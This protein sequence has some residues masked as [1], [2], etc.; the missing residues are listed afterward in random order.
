[1]VKTVAYYVLNPTKTECLTTSNKVKKPFHP[2]LISNNIQLKEDETHKH[3]R[4]SYS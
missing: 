4:V 1:M 3:V 2:S